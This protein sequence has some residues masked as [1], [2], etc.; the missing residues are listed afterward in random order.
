M[1]FKKEAPLGK[2]ECFRHVEM[3]VEDWSFTPYYYHYINMKINFY[4]Y[5]ILAIIYLNKQV[6][7]PD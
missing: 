6:L 4:M 7:K 2:R 3:A 1:G 5:S